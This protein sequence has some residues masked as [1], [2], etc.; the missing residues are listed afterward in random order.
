ML[1]SNDHSRQIALAKLQSNQLPVDDLAAMDLLYACWPRHTAKC[2]D[3]QLLDVARNVCSTFGLPTR[4]PMTSSRSWRMLDTALFANDLAD[5]LALIIEFISNWQSKST[6]F[7]ILDFCE[8]ELIEYLFESLDISR[9]APLLSEVMNFKVLSVRR[10]GLLRRIPARIERQ[11]IPLIEGGRADLAIAE[12]DKV[13]AFLESFIA[14]YGFAPIVDSAKR[15]SERV[16]RDIDVLQ[17]AADTAIIDL[18][19]Q[20]E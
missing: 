17:K 8:I 5:Q 11:L 19:G 6:E 18:D 14:P 12:L 1:A 15:A 7:L 16:A 4:L 20:I 9:Y 13:K 10:A 3:T 2:Q